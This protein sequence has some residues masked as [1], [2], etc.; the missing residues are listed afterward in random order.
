MKK[1]LLIMTV[2]CLFS[3][4]I[5]AYENEYFKIEL[6]EEFTEIKTESGVY[7]WE[8]KNKVDNIVITV[9]KNDSSTKHNIEN[10]TEEDIEE[11]GKYL[12][13]TINE[14]LKEYNIIVD[15]SNIK[16]TKI[17]NYIALE[18]DILWPTKESFGYDTFQKGYTITTTNYITAYIYTSDKEITEQNNYFFKSS[19]SIEILDTALKDESF[20]SKKYN[21]LIVIGALAGCI[22]FAI[23]ALIKRK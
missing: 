11:Y 14:E 2:F 13:D 19:S 22:G 12:E 5:K 4:N 21:R 3:I 8:L 7:K 23:S 15:V 20:F 10:Y 9:T 17:N 18:Y 16:K 1:I 6:N